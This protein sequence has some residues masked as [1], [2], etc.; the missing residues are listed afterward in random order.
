MST[1]DVSVLAD[2]I[3]LI[4]KRTSSYGGPDLQIDVINL[5]VDSML[6]DIGIEEAISYFDDE[7]VEKMAEDKSDELL[8]QI[9][10]DKVIAYFGIEEK[11]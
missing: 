11:E 8:E 5:D 6:S 3:D 10:K 1:M 4:E 2:R 9:G 7:L